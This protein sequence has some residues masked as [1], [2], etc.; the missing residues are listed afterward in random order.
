M[1]NRIKYKYDKELLQ[2]LVSESFSIREVMT[3]IGITP[4]SGG[5]HAHIKTRINKEGIDISHF[6]GKGANFG[7]KHT[8]G[9]LKLTPLEILVINS[10][11]Y[12]TKA[13]LL[14]RALL[15][16]NRPHMC[17]ICKIRGIWNEI[18]LKLEVE[19]KNGNTL[20]NREENLEFI[21]P[22]CHSQTET[23]CRVKSK[24]NTFQNLLPK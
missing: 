21:C 18:P 4:I 8:G 14:R 2:K 9:S 7:I 23:F 22:N 24:I 11:G 19:H 12:K 15:E 5:M 20:D 10:D 16:I 6:R 13:E 3:K 1:P 17:Y